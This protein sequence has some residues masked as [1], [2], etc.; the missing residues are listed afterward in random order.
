[1]SANAKGQSIIVGADG[2]PLALPARHL[3]M[4]HSIEA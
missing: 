3:P 1:M 4:S 2:S